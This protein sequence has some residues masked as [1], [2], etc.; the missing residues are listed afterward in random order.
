MPALALSPVA[1]QAAALGM[2]GAAV[3]LAAV[4]GYRA[5]KRGRVTPEERERLRRG[6]LVAHGKLTDATL[7]EIREDLL[8][9]SYLVRGVEYVASQDVAPLKA[10]VPG[11][12]GLGD[13]SVSVKYDSQNPANSIV[14]AEEWSGLHGFKSG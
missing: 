8:F 10:R 11:Q 6:A 12:L 2:A 7:V 4:L 5:W 14:L 13:S 3:A 9:Y 1:V